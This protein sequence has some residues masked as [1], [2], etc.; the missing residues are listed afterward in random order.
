MTRLHEA[1]FPYTLSASLGCVCMGSV[2]ILIAALPHL[3]RHN[4]ISTGI[5]VG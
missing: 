3:H 2:S 5:C 4:D 1:F